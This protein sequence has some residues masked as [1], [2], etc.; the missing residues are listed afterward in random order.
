MKFDPFRWDEVS[1]NAEHQ[2]SGALVVQVSK[3]AAL[4]VTALGYE[5]CAGY[6]TFFDV[7]I[8]GEYGFRVEADK[9]TRAFVQS[10]PIP[11]VE[12][13]GVIFTNHEAGLETS[14]LIYQMKKALRAQQ[15]EQAA[16]MATVR[17]ETA[18]LKA[19]AE[20]AAAAGAV[21]EVKPEAKPEDKP[22]E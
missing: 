17:E 20:A 13:S 19:A 22:V 9:G 5:V 12:A 21:S 6:G 18:K 10:P 2:S 15:I 7:S 16:L 1:V 4:F 14:G 11:A 3:P 8:Q